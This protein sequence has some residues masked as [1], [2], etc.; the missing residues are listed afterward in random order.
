MMMIPDRD[1]M[2]KTII[3][4]RI[5]LYFKLRAFPVYHDMIIRDSPCSENVFLTN[6]FVSTHNFKIT[7]ALVS[8]LWV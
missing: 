5:V 7:L 1:Y 4:D 3:N 2:F 8:Y 6:N